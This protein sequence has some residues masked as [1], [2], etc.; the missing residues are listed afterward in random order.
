MNHLGTITIETPRLLLR[1]FV[2]EDA[3][4]AFQNWT[5]DEKV[6]RNLYLARPRRKFLACVTESIPQD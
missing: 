3:A 6:G 2:K 5:S 4:A 1:R